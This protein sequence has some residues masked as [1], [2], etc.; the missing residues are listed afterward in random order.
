MIVPMKKVTLLFKNQTEDDAHEIVEK[1]RDFG[2]FHFGLS[3]E[4]TSM[5]E[6]M[7]EALGL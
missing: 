4:S 7:E 1:L 6:Q 2:A 5:L 3:D